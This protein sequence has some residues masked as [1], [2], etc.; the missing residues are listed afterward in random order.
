MKNNKKIKFLVKKTRGGRFFI[1]T[2]NDNDD[3]L[4]TFLKMKVTQKKCFR[5]SVSTLQQV[6]V[7]RHKTRQLLLIS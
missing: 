7:I 6:A 1:W 3:I 2:L 4:I 5:R